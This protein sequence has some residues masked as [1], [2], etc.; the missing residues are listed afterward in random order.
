MKARLLTYSGA[1]GAAVLA[2]LLRMSLTPWVGHGMPFA[3][4]FVAILVVAWYGSLGP[5]ILALVLSTA[6]GTYLFILPARTSP[7]V[8][9]ARVDRITVFGFVFISL[10]ASILLDLQRKTL[11]RA[12][13]E[14]ARRRS[15]EEAEREQRQWFETTLASIGDAVI[16]TDGEGR[17]IFMNSVAARLTGWEPADARG[18]PLRQ[19]F[20]IVNEQT[21]AP[22][23]NPIEKVIREGVT[24]GLANH[25]VL[26]A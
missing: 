2:I 5:A 10:V 18:L 11:R 15:A 16:A 3:I 26:I 25:T 24:V 12:E 9:A 20:E 21:S 1:V 19:V 14:T 17:V 4:S 8:L 13:R 23:E 22:L 6:A 7:F